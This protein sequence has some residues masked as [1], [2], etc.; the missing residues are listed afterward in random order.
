MISEAMKA[1]EVA[2]KDAAE[3]LQS[4]KAKAD[5]IR[6]ASIEEAEEMK[7]QAEEGCKADHLEKLRKMESDREAAIQLAK[8]DAEGKAQKMRES[9]LAKENEAIDAVIS[10]II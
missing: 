3:K 10:K 1:V 4:A 2:E 9:M 5:D 7:R 8:V 6:K